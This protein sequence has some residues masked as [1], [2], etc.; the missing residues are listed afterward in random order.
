MPESASMDDGRNTGYEFDL[1]D[2]DALEEDDFMGQLGN[3]DS[4]HEA[5]GMAAIIG[6]RFDYDYEVRWHESIWREADEPAV[7]DYCGHEEHYLP[8]VQWTFAVDYGPDEQGGAFCCTECFARW[9]WERDPAG[10]R[11]IHDDN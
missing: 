1:V 7:C 9:A 10:L 3:Y 8:L 2:R 5:V 4:R 6:R 11:R